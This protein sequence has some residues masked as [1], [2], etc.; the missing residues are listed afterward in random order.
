MVIGLIKDELSEKI[1]KE[2]VGLREKTSSYL[3]ENGS[4]DKKDKRHKKV[5][6]KT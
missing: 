2:F 3:I 4:E 6:H 5:Y 1:V